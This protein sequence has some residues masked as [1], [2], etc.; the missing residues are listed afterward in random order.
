MS[1][2]TPPSPHPEHGLVS[3]QPVPHNSRARLTQLFL[4]HFSNDA[5]ANFLGQLQPLLVARFGLSLAAAGGLASASTVVSSLS[6]PFFGGLA[7]R[8]RRPWFVVLGP[9]A[10]AV[11]MSC[12]P[13]APSVPLLIAM[14]LCGGLGSALFH[15]QAAT[16]ASR[17]SGPDRGRDMAFFITG[18][19]IGYSLGPLFVASALKLLGTQHVYLMALPGLVLT[20]WVASRMLTARAEPRA[21]HARGTTPLRGVIVPLSMLFLVVVIRSFVSQSFA[22]FLPLLVA[23]QTGQMWAGAMPTSLYL[24]AGAMGGFAGGPLADRFGRKSLILVSM[25]FSAPF[26]LGFLWLHGPL[27]WISLFMGGA[28]LQLSLPVNVVYAQ[29]LFP[30]QMSTVSGLMMGFAWGV[31]GLAL[32]AVGWLADRYG[33]PIALGAVGLTPLLGAMLAAALPRDRRVARN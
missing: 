14:L 16:W 30:E 24:L 31:A 11:F 26:V 29:E 27:S 28:I 5:Y 25:L 6:Q 7:D 13:L 23:R 19:S 15:P 17:W 12:L 21:E 18:G 4:V 2:A 10:T 22:Q 33:L 9:L 3:A 8:L 32:A 1:L 20:L